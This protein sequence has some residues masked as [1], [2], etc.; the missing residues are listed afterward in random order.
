[1][2]VNFV[3]V[4]VVF[5]EVFEDFVDD[6]FG[7]FWFLNWVE[8]VC[9]EGGRYFDFIGCFKGFVFIGDKDFF[10]FFFVFKLVD[11]NFVGVVIGVYLYVDF[12]VGY[13]VFVCVGWDDYLGVFLFWV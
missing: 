7:L 2:G 6:W 4:N 10:G 12:V 1:M 9:E 3:Y 13:Y 8:W 5:K 11:F